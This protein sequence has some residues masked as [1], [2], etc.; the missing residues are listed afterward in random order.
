MDLHSLS[1][2]YSSVYSVSR[3]SRRNGEETQ[4]CKTRSISSRRVPT[5]LR[6]I[7]CQPSGY[8][9]NLILKRIQLIQTEKLFKDTVEFE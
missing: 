4:N 8:E 9:Y 1:S 5:T 7:K 2:Y 3:G 6:N